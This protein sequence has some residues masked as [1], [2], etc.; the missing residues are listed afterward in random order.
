MSKTITPQ[1]GKRT[2]PEKD[3]TRQHNF[4]LD[5]LT[6]D[7]Y[8]LHSLLVDH[9]DNETQECWPHETSLASRMMCSVR[10]VKM[11]LKRLEDLHLVAIQRTLKGNRYTLLRVDEAALRERIEATK[12]PQ[13]ES[14]PR[15]PSKVHHVHSAGAPYAPLKELDPRTKPI[16]L[17][18][19][20]PN[21]PPAALAKR[22]RSTVAPPALSDDEREQKAAEYHAYLEGLKHP[23]KPPGGLPCVITS[24]TVM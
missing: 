10:L 11:L 7:E 5:L 8:K 1:G 12:T 24:T 22:A 19:G 17:D 6:A 15:A 21:S 4:L 23:R 14:A 20:K 13:T 2:M 3:Y 16:E 9:A 18:G